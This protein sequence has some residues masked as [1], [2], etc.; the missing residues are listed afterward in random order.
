M[1]GSKIKQIYAQEILDSRGDPTVEAIVILENGLEVRASVPAGASAGKYEALELRDKDPD[2]F[3][4]RGVLKACQN[5]QGLIAPVLVGLEVTEQQLIDKK[6]IEL[7]GTPKKS[8]LGANATIAVSLACA[9]AGAKLSGLPI[10]KYLR[11]IYNLNFKDYLLPLCAYNLI[12]G[13]K[14]AENKTDVQEFLIV[15]KKKK[16]FENL[17]TAVEIFQ[18][19][20][21]LVKNIYGYSVAVGDEGGFAPDIKNNSEGLIMISEAIQKTN[22]RLGEEV[23]LGADIAASVFY[24]PEKNLYLFEGLFRSAEE[25]FSVY[26]SWVKRYPML[27]LEDPWADDDWL[28]WET[29]GKKLMANKDFILIGDDI[30]VTNTERLK[31]GIERGV[32]NAVIIKLNQVGTLTETI[33]CIELA[34]K[35]KYKIMIAHRSGETNDDFISD[36][37][38]AVNAEFIKTGAPNRGER[39]AKYNR[40]LEIERELAGRIYDQ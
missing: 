24:N 21:N 11:Q 17:K 16:F 28:A 20:K 4:G 33:A 34:R 37:A 32:A 7:D 40:L 12:N 30:F 2:R 25:M 29:L 22:Y 35:Y 15:P 18:V 36:L 13:G 6:M 8:R 26:Q 5:I 9:R 3:L 27:Y 14:H 38:V 1:T 23:V 19:L 10:Y 39:I 31:M